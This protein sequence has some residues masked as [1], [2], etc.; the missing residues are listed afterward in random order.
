MSMLLTR[1]EPATPP[2]RRRVVAQVLVFRAAIAVAGLAVLDDAFVHPEQ[3]TSAGEHLVGGLVP[4]AIAI[5]L[6]IAYPRLRA[7]LRGAAAIA[8]GL[9]ALTAG[10]ADGFRHVLVD[11]LAGDDVLV[12]AAGVA[13]VV[14]VGLGATTLWRARR[15]DERRLRR[16]ARRAAVVTLA[17]VGTLFVLVPTMIAIV[18]THRAREPVAS[19][20]LGRPHERVSLTTAD[21]VQLAGWY[22][23][24]RNRAAVVVSP[25][26]R[27]PIPQARMLVRHGYG[28]LVFDRRGEGESDGDFNAYGWGGDADLKA[29][30]G[31]LG[32]RADVDPQRIGGLGLSVGGEMLL[33]AAAED[34]RLRAVVSEGASVRS[35]AEHWD[36]PGIPAVVKPF[37]PKVAQTLAVGVLANEGP[38][39]S[40]MDLVDDIAPRSLLLIRGLD[41]QPAEILNRAFYDAAGSPKHLWEVPGAGHTAAISAAPAEYERRVVGFLDRALIGDRARARSRRQSEKSA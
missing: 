5:G 38:P 32:E 41:G 17:G 24:S 2:A 18:A 39:P 21:G 9:L 31:F 19:V 11:R 36:D 33:E 20:D 13:G 27:G 34:R 30:V 10:V 6:A 4:V 23:P 15:H 29:A 22:V 8:C 3:G 1:R 16:S 26:R 40:L 14:L 28:V 25:G 37:T 7:G 12:M 35:L